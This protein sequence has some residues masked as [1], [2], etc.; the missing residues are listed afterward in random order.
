MRQPGEMPHRLE[1]AH[2][3][4]QR[5]L[6]APQLL[7]QVGGRGRRQLLRPLIRGAAARMRILE[8]HLLVAFFMGS[9]GDSSKLRV[10]PARPRRA[11]ST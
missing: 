3:R 8:D 10:R 7:R 5:P 9:H 6:R 4:Q 1:L 11:P 2:F